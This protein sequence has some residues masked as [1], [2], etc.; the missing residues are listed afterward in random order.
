MKPPLQ[1]QNYAHR[2][3]VI[4]RIIKAQ[5]NIVKTRPPYVNCAD[6]N[7]FAMG[8]T[9]SSSEEIVYICILPAPFQSE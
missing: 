3:N 2:R 4:L 1:M 5:F 9:H 8:P 7:G 6:I